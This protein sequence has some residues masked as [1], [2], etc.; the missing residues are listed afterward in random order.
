MLLLLF[1]CVASHGLVQPNAIAL[2]L[3]PHGRQ[4][5][6][7]SALIGGTQFTAAAATGAL[8]GLLHNGTALPMVG[9]IAACGA[10]AF[11]ILQRLAKRIAHEGER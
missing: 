5:G 9:V 6:S 1:F 10:A 11:L 7:A 2:A 3:A 4:A 8:V